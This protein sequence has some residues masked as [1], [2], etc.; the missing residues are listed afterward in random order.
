MR[1]SEDMHWGRTR[2]GYPH[3]AGAAVNGVASWPRFEMRWYR[4]AS[5]G[6]L[7]TLRS[8]LSEHGTEMFARHGI[9]VLSTWTVTMGEPTP[10]LVYLCEFADIGHRHAAWRAVDADRAWQQAKREAEQVGGGQMVR[11]IDAWWLEAPASPP[12]LP[13]TELAIV[14]VCTPADHRQRDAL[15]SSLSAKSAAGTPAAFRVLLG[16]AGST[17]SIGESLDQDVLASAPAL[18]LRCLQLARAPM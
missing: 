15:W 3:Q 10:T 1:D 11:S 5:P 9:D 12:A 18:T 16:P 7:Q 4:C 13:A 2:D 17:V 6:R 14:T 8:L